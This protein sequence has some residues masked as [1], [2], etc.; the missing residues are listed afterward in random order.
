MTS[1][2]RQ[3]PGN[4]ST[5]ALAPQ[6]RVA[7]HPASRHGEGV[8][9]EFHSI[10]HAFAQDD[11]IVGV[12]DDVSLHVAASEF[13]S[14]VGP[15]GCGKTTL[16]SMACGLTKPKVGRVIVDGRPLDGRTL[17][18]AA[19]MLA[20]DA[21][22]PWRNACENVEFGLEVRGVEAKTR[23]TIA[24][25]WLERVGLGNYAGARV[26]QLSQGMRQRVAIARTLALT[27]RLL[28]MDEPFAALDAQ[29]RVLIQEEFLRL[30]ESSRATVLFI[31]HDLAEAIKL[32]DRVVLLGGTPTR[33]TSDLRIDLPR[34]RPPDVEHD[35]PKFAEYYNSLWAALREDVNRAAV[36]K[37]VGKD[38]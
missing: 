7:C 36:K 18:E 26:G 24:L 32:S 25:D 9:V 6:R 30:W 11:K 14:V 38:G 15:S 4:S 2:Y 35:D 8:S 16:L 21:L 28:L 22:L 29:T 17:T 27:P 3:V 19:Y 12:L 1:W 34:P 5:A 10:S 37:Y 33:I 23:K 31:T 13:V 20:R